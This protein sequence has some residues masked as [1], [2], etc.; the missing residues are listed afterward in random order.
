MKDLDQE[1]IDKFEEIL[2]QK[3]EILELIKKLN[4][5][6]DENRN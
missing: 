2:I 5:Q 3:R 4:K 6:E 1:I